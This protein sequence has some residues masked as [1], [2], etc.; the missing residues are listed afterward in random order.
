MTH[1]GTTIHFCPKCGS[2]HFPFDG[3]KSFKCKQCG[4]HF[5]INTAAAVAAIII[6]PKGE[7]L[8]TVRAHAPNQGM[9]D[10]P[11]GFVD[12]HESAEE[13]LTREIKEEL[14]LDVIESEY[15]ISFPNE[16]VFSDFTVYTTDL[17]FKVK[18]ADF[19]NVTACDDISDYI[20]VAPENIDYS[21]IGAP[22][23]Q[24][25]LQHYIQ[26]HHIK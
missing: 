15:L 20:F 21:N 5:F 2:N 1:P 25:I 18:V 16:Y 3:H 8:L 23:I 17:A 12:P 26:H 4:F 9:L 10:L 6:N 22:S 7:I 24:K 13:A 19:A 11:G 14:H